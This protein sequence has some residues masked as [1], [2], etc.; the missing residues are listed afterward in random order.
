MKNERRNISWPYLL[1]HLF[2]HISIR[3]KWQI[4]SMFFLIIMASFS[5]VLSIG[6]ILPFLSVLTQP[7]QLFSNSYIKTIAQYFGIHTGLE[8]LL[9]LT[10]LFCLSAIFAN[11]MRFFTLLANVRVSNG[12]GF[13]LSMTAYRCALYQPYSYHLNRNSSAVISDIAKTNA[14]TEGVIL[15]IL[16][17]ISGLILLISIIATLFVINP[18]VAIGTFGGFGLIYFLIMKLSN[19][20]LAISSATIATESSKVGQVLYEGLGGIR[21]IILNSTQEIFC[22]IY[23]KSSLPNRYAQGNSMLLANGPHYGVEAIGMSL[24]GMVAFLLAVKSDGGVM[25]AVPTLGALVLGAQRILPILQRIYGSIASI[26]S[27]KD[28]LIDA[29]ELLDR[30]YPPYISSGAITKLPFKN[31]IELI[32]IKFRYNEQLPLVLKGINLV[33]MKGDRIGI[34]GKTGGGKSTFLDIFMGLLNP[35]EGYIKVD[36][37]KIDQSNLQEW[38]AC[39]AHVPQTIFIADSSIAENI[40]F[41]CPIE[42]IDFD[43]VRRA[44]SSAGIASTIES[45]T[46]SYE[47]VVGERGVRLSGGQRQR[48]GIARALYKKAEVLVLD[49]ATSSLDNETEGEV[50]GGIDELSADV[51]ILMVAHRLTTLKNCNKIIQIESGVIGLS[52]SYKE[53]VVEGGLLSGERI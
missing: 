37:Q 27:N 25:A 11:L 36:S 12:I 33:I 19:R 13:E 51:T 46:D 40:A 23:A 38:Q 35:S 31:S 5:E 4:L 14:L 8:L 15:P 41:G 24:I 2:S 16:N 32:D 52:G 1:R 50:I 47:T 6:L 43:R 10:I 30:P 20:S 48:I 21:D 3:R 28:N 44:A 7:E 26:K 17:I 45:W 53:L 29:L 22:T 39:I 42:K 34:M 18:M 9:P 49:E